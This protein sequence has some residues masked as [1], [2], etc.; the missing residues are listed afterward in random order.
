MVPDPRNAPEG[1]MPPFCN[2]W[3]GDLRP[4][5]FVKP[6]VPIS[7]DVRAHGLRS[8]FRDW[9]AE[10]SNFP[11]EACEMALA[12]TVENCIEVAYRRG[13]L[14]EKQRELMDTWASFVVA[15]AWKHFPRTT[16]SAVNDKKKG[17]DSKQRKPPV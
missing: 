10:Q 13:D 8:S 2:S 4:C 14:F 3:V 12:H 7:L 1:F 6:T 15:K 9:A 11:R 16:L 5:A 17:S